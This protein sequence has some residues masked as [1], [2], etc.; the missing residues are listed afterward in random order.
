MTNKKTKSSTITNTIT[1]KYKDI[2]IILRKYFECDDSGHKNKDYDETYSAQDCI[3]DIHNIVG[4][5]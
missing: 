3:D 4:K 5:I 1:D 2:K